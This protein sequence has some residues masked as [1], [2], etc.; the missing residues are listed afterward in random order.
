[1]VPGGLEVQTCH[2]TC[3]RHV[4]QSL[5]MAKLKLNSSLTELRGSIEGFVVRHTRHGSILSRSPDM[6]RVKWSPAQKARRKL[7]KSAADH[8]RAVMQDPKQATRYRALAA[9]QKIP[10]SSFVMGEYLRRAAAARM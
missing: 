4:H 2:A 10:V 8:Y 7:M 1:M 5:L 9:R 3:A 6:S